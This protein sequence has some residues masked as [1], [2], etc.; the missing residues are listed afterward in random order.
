MTIDGVQTS[1][2]TGVPRMAHI[3]DRA[4]TELVP[5]YDDMGPDGVRDYWRKKNLHTIDG[6]ETGLFDD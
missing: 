4:Q 2:G 1:C 3:A 6:F 5:Y